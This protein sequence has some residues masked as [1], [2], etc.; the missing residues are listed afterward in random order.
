MRHLRAVCGLATAGLL[1]GL[2]TTMT[3]GTA[4]AQ[5]PLTDLDAVA[6]DI[7]ELPDTLKLGLDPGI[8]KTLEAWR[9]TPAGAAQYGAAAANP[10]V[11]DT[12]MWPSLDQVQSSVYLKEY[13]LR[14]VG[15][16]IE[17]W[18]ASGA[19]PDGI[20]GTDFR[21]EDCRNVIKNSTT[22]TDAQVKRLMSEYDNKML[23]KES[24]AFSVAPARDGSKPVENELTKGLS[25]TGAGNNVV[26][27]VDNV[28]D[29]NFYDFPKNQ[30]YVAGFFSRQFNELTDRNIM[31]ID[32]YD[33]A[34]RTGV[35]PRD[36]Q[37]ADD[38]CRSRPARPNQYEGVFAHEYQHLLHYYTDP[39]EGNFLNEGLSDYAESLV[40]YG[41]TTRTVFQKSNESHLTCFNG[42]GT[43]GTKYNPNPQ[44]CGGP[45]NS[46]TMWGDEG[47]GSEILADYGNAWSFLLFVLDRFGPRVLEDL[48]RDKKYQGIKSV[49]IALDKYA[50]GTKVADVL[51]DFQ[52]STLLDKLV[53]NGKVTG[54]DRKRILAKSLNSSVNLL[55]PAAY[56]KGGVAPN[57]ADYVPLR[58]TGTGFLR[59][60]QL[61][62]LRFTGAKAL[63]AGPL[64]WSVVPKT[65]LLPPVVLPAV[66]NTPPVDPIV[67]PELGPLPIDKPALF[68]GN[69]GS[70]DASAVFSTTVPADAPTFSYTSS[71]SMEDGFDWGYTVVST[72][73]GKTWES[74][75]NTNTRPTTSPAPAGNALTGSSGIPVTQTF[76]LTEYAGKKVLIG[77]RY[78]SDPLIN[79][80]GW[81]V[82]D[83]K[84]GNKV[85]SDGTTLKGFKSFTQIRPVA[86]PAFT[87]TLVG[88]DEVGKR[89]HVQRIKG[90]YNAKLTSARLKAFAS[91]PVVVAVISLDDIAEKLTAYAPYV[92]NVNG[93][94]QEGGK[95]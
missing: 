37:D 83:V 44:A 88:I 87:V 82:S 50:K 69:D 85:I 43:V 25:F 91:Y 84:L 94:I 35:D 49:Q 47:E 36:D 59:G 20:M 4:R 95:L 48:H 63:K 33:W 28:R 8:T 40:G 14:G 67:A 29:P 58:T 9:A 68:S 3:G 26:T 61:E 70:E 54:I 30:T 12:R 2:T 77:F 41:N 17:V 75:V 86:V 73:G 55:N 65:P 80:G 11:G 18:V 16:N 34:H 22:I 71:H 76:D 53:T 42:Y 46:L 93:V 72:N 5:A 13:T 24:K 57:G 10:K 60:N 15:K 78:V 27:L 23:P 32:A 45:Q 1:L 31:S 56:L 92:L 79:N 51:H 7:M 21:A 6:S 39:D 64:Q 19:G 66:P 90:T 74:L 81:Y 89:A 38:I 62:S 52:L